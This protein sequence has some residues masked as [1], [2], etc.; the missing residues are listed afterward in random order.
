M[1]GPPEPVFVLYAPQLGENIGAAAR[2]MWNFG[3]ARLRL[4]APR[5]GWPNPDAVAMASGATRVLDRAGTFADL[6]GA[7]ADLHRVYATTARPRELTKRVLTPDAAVSE[8]RAHLAAGE[9]V[10]FLFGPERAGLDNDAVA[11]ASAIVTVPTNPAFPSLNLA[12]S[13]L[14]MAWEWRRQGMAGPAVALS[15]PGTRPATRIETEKLT[16]R[17]IGALDA[18]GFFRPEAKAPGMRR[19]LTNMLGRLPLTEADV[20]T[21]H[22]AIRAL[23]RDR[24]AP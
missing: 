14:L 23:G 11:C 21:L 13:V 18:A 4:V 1:D 16:E 5:D 24:D 6:A 22:G 19:T 3:L 15:T 20:K 8:A 9:R 17:L 12:Q 10:G 2:A 7:T